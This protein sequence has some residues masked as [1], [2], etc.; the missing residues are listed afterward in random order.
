MATKTDDLV[1]NVFK[2]L[3]PQPQIKYLLTIF[4]CAIYG[5]TQHCIPPY[6][7]KLWCRIQAPTKTF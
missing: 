5:L 4:H 7:M 3:I 6:S 2:A 1:L